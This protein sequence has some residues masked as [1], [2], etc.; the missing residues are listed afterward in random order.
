MPARIPGKAGAAALHHMLILSI[1][2]C[3]IVV[4]GAALLKR[5]A[6]LQLAKKWAAF[7]LTRI[8]ANCLLGQS[9]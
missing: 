9:K 5:L 2:L 3:F 7:F 4:Q 1:E 6:A 8:A